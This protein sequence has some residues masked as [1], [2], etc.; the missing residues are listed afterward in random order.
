MDSDALWRRVLK[1]FNYGDVLIT[2]GTGELTENE[3]RGLGL[4]GEHDYSI[5]DIKEDRGQRLFLVKNP[6][7]NGQVWKGHIRYQDPVSNMDEQLQCLRGPETPGTFWMPLNDVFLSFE[8]IYL[9]WNPALFSFRNDVHFRW[10]LSKTESPDGCL[11]SNPQYSIRSEIAGV[12][13][14]LLSRHFS[15]S[16]PKN[17]VENDAGFISLYAFH[18]D[19]QRVIL[20]D[21]AIAH[22]PYVDSP[23]ALLKVD[24]APGSALTIV[25]SE[26]TLPRKLNRFSLSAFSFSPLT[27]IPASEKY[28]HNSVVC[29]TWTTA[30]SGGNTGSPLYH[31]NPQFSIALTQQSNVCLL[32]QTTEPWSVHVNL[33]WSNGKQIRSVTTRDV[34]GDSGE[35]RKGC[36]CTEIL[37]VPIGTYTIVCSTFEPN[38][39]GKFELSVGTTVPSQIAR[40]A[41][42]AAGKFVTPLRS[43]V[44]T[45]RDDRLVAAFVSRR[46]NRVSVSAKSRQSPGLGQQHC[47]LLRVSIEQGWGP[48][49]RMLAV[50][51][52]DSFRDAQS[53]GVHTPDVD[54][55]PE[56]C[57]Q[58]LRIVL[59]W[60]GSSDVPPIEAVDVQVLSDAPIEVGAWLQGDSYKQLRWA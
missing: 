46:L 41:T 4:A 33:V 23:N 36:T 26:Q 55:L 27:L 20:S 56:M 57:A 50:S 22:G 39:T 8:S 16:P 38:Q 19:G 24:L 7:S 9:N 5:I 25:V 12:V 29:G 6:W 34:V 17:I 21:G 52:E 2:M 28:A 35:Y 49:T 31:V 60:L 10:D 3:E 53:I 45:P 13:W 30:T 15:N 32:L 47:S 59:D 11:W 1:A 40:V 44:W 58:G 43:V 51:E 42:S 18:S 54:I 14:L 37:D 48:T